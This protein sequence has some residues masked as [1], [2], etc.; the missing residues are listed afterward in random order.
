MD[1]KI[2]KYLWILLIVCILLAPIVYLKYDFYVNFSSKTE[3]EFDIEKCMLESIEL[4]EG[5]PKYFVYPSRELC[6][7]ASNA[8]IEAVKEYNRK[9]FINN[10]FTYG[11]YLGFHYSYIWIT[12]F[13]LLL[14][15]SLKSK[16]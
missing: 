2:I 9:N 8:G 11:A 1:N 10:Y 4:N 13:I 12:I 14:I 3:R 5:Y 15:I 6:K 16:K 7:E